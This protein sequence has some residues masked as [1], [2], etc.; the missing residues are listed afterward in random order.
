M[1]PNV[2]GADSKR[3]KTKAKI[4][5]EKKG[6]TIKKKSA[7]KAK[8]K[9]TALNNKTKSPKRISSVK[10]KKTNVKKQRRSLASVKTAGYKIPYIKRG[11]LFR[12]MK[13]K[14]GDIV[15]SVDK[16]PVY[17]KKQTRKILSKA[18]N[19]KK[20]FSVSLVRNKKNLIVSYKVDSSQS[21]KKNSG[22]QHTK[23]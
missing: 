6:N 16:Q 10:A 8:L 18:F 7:S 20:S 15:Q 12:K 3:K 13:L 4:Q 21:E 19:K 2:E 5:N 14:K 11:G 9:N 22:F 23:S 17:S 1:A